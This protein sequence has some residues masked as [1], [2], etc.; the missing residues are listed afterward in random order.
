MPVAF[1]NTTRRAR[2]PRLAA[3]TRTAPWSSALFFCLLFTLLFSA[4][5]HAQSLRVAAASDLQFAFPD[6]AAQFEKQ[7]GVKLAATYGS[8]G[9]FVAQ[10]QNGAPFDLFLSADDAQPRTLV[11]AGF[12]DAESLV[13][14]AQGY[15]VIWLPP[16][17]PL[18][19]TARGFRT[20][21]DPRIQKIAIANPEHAPYGRAAVFAMREAGLYEQ[22]KSKLV[23][24]EN[25]SQAA[26]FVQSGSAQAGL[27]ARSLALSPAMK[28][29]KRYELSG[30]HF[31]PL[32]QAAV[33]LKSSTNKDAAKAFLE[34]LKTPEARAIFERF[35]YS[36]PLVSLSL[37]S[38]Q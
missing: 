14:Y 33:V 4:C 31:P 19:L 13:I 3:R 8:S 21:L 32:W 6:L 23:L 38:A 16:D 10:I 2:F 34:F 30:W 36:A 11:K 29:G 7:S 27:I 9:N 20:L 1:L 22:L 37:E 17:S 28:S 15:L 35:G 24:G 12:A 25:I 26:Q 18:D 5:T